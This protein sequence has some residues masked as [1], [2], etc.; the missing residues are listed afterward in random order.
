[1]NKDHEEKNLL[2]CEYCSEGFKTSLLINNHIDLKHRTNGY[3]CPICQKVFQTKNT[4]SI[5]ITQAHKGEIYKCD[6]CPF[7]ET[8]RRIFVDHERIH[9]DEYIEC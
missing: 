3:D 5:H 4:L 1:M 9:G 8:Q 6:K 7:E 2:V